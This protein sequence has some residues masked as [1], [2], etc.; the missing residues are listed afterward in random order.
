MQIKKSM[1]KNNKYIYKK[2]YI[3][4]QSKFVVCEPNLRS[5]SMSY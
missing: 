1:E 5:L 4:L 2:N 3:K